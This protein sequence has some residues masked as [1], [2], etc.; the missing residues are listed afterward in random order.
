MV[1][2]LR[3]IA[4]LR[5]DQITK[6]KGEI[7]K[8][9]KRTT[10]GLREVLFNQ[11]DGLLSGDVTPQQAKAVVGLSAQIVSVTRLE[12]DAARFVADSR[13]DNGNTK[14]VEVKL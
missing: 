13:K 8:D 5:Y 6:N 14:L 9:S 4:V 3:K 2:L 7:M 1:L 12:M 11:M 10:A